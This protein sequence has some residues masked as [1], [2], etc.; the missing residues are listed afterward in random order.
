TLDLLLEIVD[1]TSK[2]LPCLLQGHQDTPFEDLIGAR[3]EI[4]RMDLPIPACGRFFCVIVRRERL[5]G[6]ILRAADRRH[7]MIAD[8]A[9]L[10]DDAAVEDR[11]ER[12]VAGFDVLVPELDV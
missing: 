11:R 12:M 7:P 10:E 3:L 5:A 9:G 4:R 8:L 2:P 6:L 1:R